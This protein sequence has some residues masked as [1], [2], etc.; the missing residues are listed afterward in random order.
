[1]MKYYSKLFLSALLFLSFSSV[2][3]QTANFTFN[4]H[5]GCDVV[6]VNFTNTST[7]ASSYVWTSNSVQFSTL[8]SPTN[9]FSSPGSYAITLTINGGVSSHT[10]TVHVWQSPTASF[11]TISDTTCAGVL[12]QF[13]ST[14]TAGSG[15]LVQYI[16][17]WGD[18]GG[19]TVTTP[20]TTHLYAFP[21]TFSANLV[22]YD[23][24]G[25]HSQSIPHTIHVLPGPNVSF[26]MDTAYGC[27]FPNNVVFTN[28]SNPGA[29]SYLWTFGDPS[30]GANDSATTTNATHLYN[31]PGTYT[32][33]LNGVLGSC[34]DSYTLNYYLLPE[35]ASFSIVND[36]IC[37]GDTAFFS[38]TSNPPAGAVTWNFGDPGS[39]ANNTST[40]FAPFHLFS[41][42]GLFTIT[43][44]AT[45]A[46]T[47][48]TSSITHTVFV[49]PL[50]V[51]TFTNTDSTHCSPPWP[52]TF[53]GVGSNIANWN[54]NFGDGSTA[55]TA[56]STITHPYTQYGIIDTIG[57][58][59]T[60][61]Y[62]C[63]SDTAFHFNDVQIVAPTIQIVSQPDS[64]C[65]PRTVTITAAATF[66]L[67]DGASNITWDFGDGSPVTS[68][69]LTVSHNY[70]YVAPGIYT[71]I[72]TMTTTDGCTVSDTVAGLIRVGNHVSLTFDHDKDTVCIGDIIHFWSTTPRPDP[73]ISSYNWSF[74]GQ[75]SSVYMYT[76]NYDTGWVW[77]NLTCF[78]NGCGDSTNYID[79]VYIQGPKPI[80]AAAYNCINR[81][82]V[83]FQD[84][85]HAADSILW[86]FGDGDTSTALNPSHL[87]AAIGTY[88]V[89]LEAWNF[90]TGCHY[91]DTIPV[92]VADAQAAISPFPDTACYP[93]NS[94]F[95]GSGSQSAVT[96]S[97]NFNDPVSGVL[98]TSLFPD[99]FHLFVDT[100]NYSVRLIV[101]DVHGCL[102]TA[103]YPVKVIG[104]HAHFVALDSS[105]CMPFNTSF[106]AGASDDFGGN[107]TQYLWDFNYAT[108]IDSIDND[109]MVS[110]TYQT[111]GLYT[112]RLITTDNNGCKDTLDQAS[113]IRVLHPYPTVV[114]PDTFLC[115]TTPYTYVGSVSDISG[116]GP[117]NFVWD[118]G[119][120][121]V[122]A[123]NGVASVTDVAPPHT[124][125]V[126]DSVY[127]I[128][129]TVTDNEG[130]VDS[131]KI[132]V[133]VLDP[134]ANAS[135]VATDSCGYTHAEFA[136]VNNTFNTQW[137]WNITGPGGYVSSSIYQNPV[138][139]FTVPGTYTTS[140]TVWNGGCS[141]TQTVNSVVVSHPAAHFDYPDST[142]CPPLAIP[143]TTHLDGTTPYIYVQWVFGDGHTANTYWPDSTY[144]YTYYTPG[145]Y[146]PN[147]LIAYTLP[148]G[149]TCLYE[150]T[151]T[152]MQPIVV[153]GGLG[154][155]ITQDTI[156][157]LEGQMDTLTSTYTD[158]N[159]AS[160]Y[161]YSW[162]VNPSSMSLPNFNITEA[163]Y[164]ASDTNDTY[165]VL[166]LTDAQGCKAYDTTWLEIK[167]CHG[168]IVVPNVF[169]PNDDGKNDTYYLGKKNIDCPIYDLKIKIFNRWGNV[170]YEANVPV[171]AEFGWD[172]KDTNGKQCSDGTYYYVLSYRVRAK[173]VKSHGY[174]Q[175]IRDKGTK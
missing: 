103:T 61:I 127:T 21:G 5:E 43:M 100:G 27:T 10:D 56:S 23:S 159:N 150:D 117:Y 18:G 167:A 149:D 29:T 67:G 95:L 165:I 64:G 9:I 164:T 85:S 54:W 166:M 91:I 31:A 22:V 128:T 6:T 34:S 94:F 71:V 44:T 7:G 86:H 35:T 68:G 3:A 63:V 79:S 69:G 154:V 111:S 115:T 121:T 106:N 8:P 52:V 87:Y 120:G 33:T 83:Q 39:G 158:L 141:A 151:N 155:N 53:T 77:I 1:M 129:L 57:V 4:P 163:I 101:S 119:D 124:Y 171:G 172:G 153:T 72:V 65:N 55:N 160:P 104:P 48:C 152:I 62:G 17:T 156:L 93:M 12:T 13:T 134:L 45:A 118:F 107:I 105:G 24:H 112:I 102:D 157:V 73:P 170:V 142:H 11:S 74:G 99:T 108:G 168:D 148:N 174:I 145:T 97:W 162:T 140:V 41:T 84:A 76:N 123:H 16:W 132:N 40:S 82:T 96:Y 144:T 138:F 169:T 38:N 37:F 143:F 146:M 19:D 135:V 98:N 139:N 36:T 78:C 136:S 2:K 80:G 92:I 14:S 122:V 50:P 60:D 125:T 137:Q 175:L 114:G 58:I 70:V 25:C 75:D 133:T 59:A 66:G 88:Q 126:N 20:V 147:A 173:E 116:S 47:N 28:T 109:A 49:R 32:V 81:Y 42:T 113:Y 51:V 30:S 26:T 90:S 131:T 110:W 46:N 130:C 161:N 89:L 15:S